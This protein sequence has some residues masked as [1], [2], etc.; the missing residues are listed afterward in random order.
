MSG[1]ASLT[2]DPRAREQDQRAWRVRDAEYADIG[3]VAAAVAELLKELGATPPPQAAMQDIAEAVVE[4]PGS[5]VLLIAEAQDRLIGLLSASWQIAMH[6]PGSYG[7]IQDLWVARAWR[8]QAVG[9]SL[10]RALEDRARA[11]GVARLEVGL[12]KESFPGLE[13]TSGFYSARGFEPLGPRMRR[14]IE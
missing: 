3:G 8:G 2:P 14:L 7:L 5:G 6:V 13:A 1:S 9:A 4:N 11:H 10:V 12:P